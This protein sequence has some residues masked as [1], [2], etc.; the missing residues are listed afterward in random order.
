VHLHR[1]P[2][3]GVTLAARFEK[4][5]QLTLMPC[6]MLNNPQGQIFRAR[7]RPIARRYWCCRRSII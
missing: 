1:S 5:S 4:A 3:P 2:Q 6:M 7:Q